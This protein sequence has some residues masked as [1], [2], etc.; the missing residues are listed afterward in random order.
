MKYIVANWKA[1]KTLPEALNWIK[2]FNNLIENNSRVKEALSIDKLSVIIAPAHP[3]IYLLKDLIT[4]KNVC[5]GTQDISS[6]EEG[7]Y[8]GEVTAK[9][10]TLA[11]KFTLV[12]H[13]E[14]RQNFHENEENIGRKIEQAQNYGIEPILCVRNTSDKIYDNVNFV[15]YEPVEAIGTGKNQDLKEIT[16]IKKQFA[17][18]TPVKFIYGGSVNE[19]NSKGYLHDQEID[20]LLIGTASLYPHSFVQILDQV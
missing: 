20:G 10:I 6:F 2:D 5:F 13:S 3:F 19:I 1:N 18:K 16:A 15:A 4:T 14:R 7:S 17:F 11:A 8:T 9:M 12:G